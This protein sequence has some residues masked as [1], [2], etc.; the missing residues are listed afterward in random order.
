M[1]R[2]HARAVARRA[3]SHGDAV[4]AWTIDRHAARS[5]DLA[6]T[7]GGRAGETL[8]VLPG[9]VDAA[10]VAVPTAAH[11]EV[12][13]VLIDAG[14]DVLVEK[15]M[16]P[17]ASAARA[18]AA[19]ADAAERTLAVGHAEWFNPAVVRAREAA[20]SAD[21]I[22]VV[23]HAECA[24][25]GL[26]LDVVEDLMLHDLDWLGRSQA[27]APR[28]CSAIGSRAPRGDLP[29]AARADDPA[30]VDEAEVELELADG[31]PARLR[32]SRVATTRRREV[33]LRRGAAQERIDL[34]DARDAGAHPEPLD[35][36]WADFLAARSQHRPPT[37][38]ARAGIAAL[39]LVEAIQAQL[40]AGGG[41]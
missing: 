9:E 37:N 11:V 30:Y 33:R 22:E 20:V 10:I 39:A 12:A 2:L 14:I 3:A 32:A 24:R 28:V 1:G 41:R 29:P 27:A 6:R 21:A 40:R 19:R 26:D 25:R 16:A 4:L 5:G 35:L 31:R 36:A 38:D 13:D 8:S 23:R 15:P 7:F 34:L 17:E 18:L